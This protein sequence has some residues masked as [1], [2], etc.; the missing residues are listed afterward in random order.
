MNLGFAVACNRACVLVRG[1]YIVFLNDDTE[2]EP[3]WLG[4]LVRTADAIP[5]AGAVGSAMFTP[6]GDL[7][8]AGSIVWRDG[9]I[10]AVSESVLEKVGPL[11]GTRQVDYCS[12]SSLLVRRSTW[13][14]VGGFDEGYY[15]A[16]FEDVDLC[17]KITRN[18][19]A[20]FCD[21][22]SRVR[23][24]R[25]SS[26]STFYQEFLLSRNVKRFVGRWSAELADRE[27]QRPDDVAALRRAIEQ[28]AERPLTKRPP[29]VGAPS[30]RADAG[31][32]TP[33]PLSHLDELQ[34]LRRELE[35]QEGYVSALEAIRLEREELV[36]HLAEQVD[37]W[38]ART[39]EIEQARVA[40][41]SELHAAWRERD[42]AIEA[43]RRRIS[44]RLADKLTSVL[45]HVPGSIRALRWVLRG[46]G[47]VRR[48]I[49]GRSV[50][51]A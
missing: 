18:G 51:E 32:S 10:T 1:E 29:L 14:A 26:S 31:S 35:N 7:A 24:N 41:V 4:A 42:E 39:A 2:V 34:F 15:P 21:Q 19:E 12:A 3:G 40:L 50:A 5:A 17:F 45:G 46:M 11:D 30:D 23:H 47:R 48:G 8:E 16:Y 28:A 22:S 13:D 43:F 6:E 49:R 36:A 9:G 27:V 38:A 37:L 20:V 33:Q 25:G 44:V